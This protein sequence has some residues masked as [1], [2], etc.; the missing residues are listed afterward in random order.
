MW[1]RRNRLLV[2]FELEAEAKEKQLEGKEQALRSR[3][4]GSGWRR[5]PRRRIRPR[6]PRQWRR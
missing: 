2:E 6:A 4:A 3:S 5:L 1:E